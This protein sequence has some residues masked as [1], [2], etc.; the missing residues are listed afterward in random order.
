MIEIKG[1]RPAP[2]RM[3]WGNVYIKF[4]EDVKPKLVMVE[5]LTEDTYRAWSNCTKLFGLVGWKISDK[6]EGWVYYDLPK[7]EFTIFDW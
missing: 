1:K 3:Y 5:P 7:E 2:N 4:K 6:R